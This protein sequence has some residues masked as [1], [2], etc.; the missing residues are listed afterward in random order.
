MNIANIYAQKKDY[1]AAIGWYEKVI[2]RS[3]YREGFESTLGE[4]I[5]SSKLNSF[6]AFVDA[7]TNIAVML[8]QLDKVEAGLD[9]CQRALELQPNNTQAQVNFTDFL[10]QVGRKDE[11]IKHTWDQI[12][13]YTRKNK[14][15][16]YTGF[17]PIQI[18]SWQA[19]EKPKEQAK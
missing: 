17:E 13:L 14:D 16:K 1:K 19:P 18:K 4:V 15:P 8:V 2:A 10:R 5:Y 7:H 9:Y 11:A 3:P 6:E 12:I